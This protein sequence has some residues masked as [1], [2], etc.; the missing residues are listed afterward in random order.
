MGNASL[1]I[2]FSY[3]VIK[4]I[5]SFHLIY[6]VNIVCVMMIYLNNIKSM[7][8][9]SHQSLSILFP[10][11]PLFLNP[12]DIISGMTRHVE[13]ESYHNNTT[14]LSVLKYPLKCATRSVHCTQI[15]S[16]LYVTCFCITHFGILNLLHKNMNHNL[17]LC[18]PLT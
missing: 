13:W 10:N 15:F 2:S 1:P 18:T 3:S 4:S 17:F 8:R 5:E 9:N 14:N 16:F 11:I 7:V 6:Y 12:F